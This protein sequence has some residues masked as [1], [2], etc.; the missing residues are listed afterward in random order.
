LGD[1]VDLSC[2]TIT[3]GTL[4]DSAVAAEDVPGQEV[5][6]P[7]DNPIKPV[8]SMAVLYGNLAP[9]GAI[10][11]QAAATPRLT[12]HR[13]RAVVFEDVADM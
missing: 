11:K 4:G 6:R 5:I 2:P 1:L 3:G 8:G 7:R 13:G 12:Q 9:G 10:I